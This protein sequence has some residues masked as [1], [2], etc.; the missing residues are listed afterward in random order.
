MK[1]PMKL[2]KEMDLGVYATIS[3]DTTNAVTWSVTIRQTNGLPVPTPFLKETEINLKKQYKLVSDTSNATSPTTEPWKTYQE[4]NEDS[5]SG[6][7]EGGG[8]GDGGGGPS[9]DEEHSMGN[10]LFVLQVLVRNVQIIVQKIVKNVKG[11]LKMTW[12]IELI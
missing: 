5:G 9:E 1:K 3:V 12:E 4:V 6:E 2:R 8:E 10:F 7:G 11:R